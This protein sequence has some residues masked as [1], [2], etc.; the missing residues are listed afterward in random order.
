MSTVK[1]Q[2]YGGIAVVTIDRPAVRNAVDASTAAALA[3][4]FRAFDAAGDSAGGLLT[5]AGGAFCPS[6][7]LKAI[8]S[9]REPPLSEAGQGTIG[10]T[11]VLLTQPV[12]AAV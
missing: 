4:A 10:P 2:L 8:A 1:T 7:A 5:G 12:I 6:C 9:R 3:D 11:R